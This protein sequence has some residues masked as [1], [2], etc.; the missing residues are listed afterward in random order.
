MRPFANFIF[1][2]SF[3][4]RRKSKKNFGKMKHYK[5]KLFF[6]MAQSVIGQRVFFKI[7]KTRFFGGGKLTSLKTR[8]NLQQ[9]SNNK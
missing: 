1:F 9:N 3:L 5:I 8:Q 4:P 2:P 7:Q 6:V